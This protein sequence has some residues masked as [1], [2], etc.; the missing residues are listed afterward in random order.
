MRSLR[1]S[2][3]GGHRKKTF[4]PGWEPNPATPKYMK[5]FFLLYDGQMEEAKEAV[6]GTLYAAAW[7]HAGVL[8]RDRCRSVA[9]VLN[10]NERTHTS[11]RIYS[12]VR[13]WAV[14]SLLSSEWDFTLG[15]S[16]G[17]PASP[18][19]PASFS[20]LTALSARTRV[21]LGDESGRE[22]GDQMP[23]ASGPL[24]NINKWEGEDATLGKTHARMAT[25]IKVTL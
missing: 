2:L 17:S 12:C 8:I 7:K 6:C 21:T 14:P 19:L 24:I 16:S 18:S 25:F 5:R 9:G 1:W 11:V 23:K 10:L 13:V 15:A 20:F 4:N 3:G 22:K